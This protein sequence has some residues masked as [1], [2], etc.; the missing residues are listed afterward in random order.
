MLAL[1]MAACVGP[2]AGDS[3]VLGETGDPAAIAAPAPSMDAAGV[4]AAVAAL[5]EGELPDAPSVLGD[6]RDLFDGVDPGYCPAITGDFSIA[7]PFDGCYASDGRIWA[8]YAVYSVG[9]DYAV[10][11][12]LEADASVTYPDG[13]T[14]L[15]AGKTYQRVAEDGT[16]ETQVVGTWGGSNLD[17]WTGD[18]P[19]VALWAAG[20]AASVT[21][22]GGVS[23]AEQALYVS[24]ATWD[25]SACP[26]ATGEVRVRD[27]GGWWYTVTLDEDC[28]GCGTLSY[29][30]QDLG[31]ACLDLGGMIGAMVDRVEAK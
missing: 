22:Y 30:G 16:F 12:Q 9:S 7:A 29:V 1:T 10:D 27:P 25:A 24:E 6:W 5:L 8:G 11:L 4:E 20:D 18:Q 14:F 17:D 28:S 2:P 26:G 15:A 3:A 21:F 19:S 23:R 13:S 31:T